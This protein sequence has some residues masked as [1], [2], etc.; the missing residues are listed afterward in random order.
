VFIAPDADNLEQ[1]WAVVDSD[2]CPWPETYQDGEFED[3]IRIRPWLDVA[4]RPNAAS[5]KTIV[6]PEHPDDPSSSDSD[7]E[8]DEESSSSDSDEE[9]S[10]AEDSDDANDHAD[11]DESGVNIH[12]LA[13]L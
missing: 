11:A 7:E 12:A 6:D 8:D 10:D 3:C 1:H 2:F 13:A 5:R 4:Q 9:D